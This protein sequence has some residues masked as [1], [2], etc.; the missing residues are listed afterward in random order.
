M[1]PGR[2]GEVSNGQIANTSDEY[3][4]FNCNNSHRRM[5]TLERINRSDHTQ[6]TAFWLATQRGVC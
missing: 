5:L 4:A 2:G 3:R 6:I 1:F